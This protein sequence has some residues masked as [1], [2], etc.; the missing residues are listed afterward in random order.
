M[1]EGEGG[2]EVLR[3]ELSKENVVDYL[4]VYER[5]PCV[6]SPLHIESLERFMSNSAGIVMANS[7]ES[8]RNIYQ[9]TSNIRQYTFR[10]I[11][12]KTYVV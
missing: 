5:A 1:L 12:T 7:I 3:N 9:L 11:N 8:L 4:E 6:V 10:G 2:S